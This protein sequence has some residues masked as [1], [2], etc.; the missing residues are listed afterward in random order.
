VLFLWPAEVSHGAACELGYALANA[1]HT[2]VSGS[3][4]TGSIFTSLANAR[5][6]SDLD[7]LE[8]VL[9]LARRLA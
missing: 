4:A 5:Y 9:E 6:E 2:V 7:A 8:A 1:K 3:T